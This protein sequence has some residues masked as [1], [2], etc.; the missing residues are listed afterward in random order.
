VENSSSPEREVATNA[1]RIE[2]EDPTPSSAPD[3]DPARLGRWQGV[4]AL[5][6]TG[7]VGLGLMSAA[8][9]FALFWLLLMIAVVVLVAASSRVSS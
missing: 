8:P 5:A 7:L 1:M 4:V 9:Q 3:A 2:D 6:V